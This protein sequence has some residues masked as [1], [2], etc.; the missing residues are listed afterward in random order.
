MKLFFNEKK[1]LIKIFKEIDELSDEL[2]T[3]K[4]L[5]RIAYDPNSTK[6]EREY[7]HLN[8]KLTTLR[9]ECLKHKVRDVLEVSAGGIDG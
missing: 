9:V 2:V 4:A 5:A 1:A 3:Y 7:A 8:M 6:P